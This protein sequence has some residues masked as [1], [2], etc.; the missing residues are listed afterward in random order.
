MKKYKAIK[1]SDGKELNWEL[2]RSIPIKENNEPLVQLNLY[3]EKIICHPEYFVQGIEF[4]M[5]V[6]YIREGV[7][8]ILIAAS[9]NLP[10]GYKFVIFDAF[11]PIE[12]QR[13]LFESYKEKLSKENQ[14]L[15]EEE[16]TKLTLNFVSLPSSDPTKP[17]AH[18]T[19]GSID[20]TITDKE[21]NLL[22]MGSF[23][24]DMSDIVITNYFEKKIES[25]EKLSK[26]EKTIL[27]NRRLLYNLMIEQGFTNF[28]NEW[29]HYDFGNQLWAFNSNN[30]YAIYSSTK[31]FF[32]WKD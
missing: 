11:R 9:K 15:N 19:G 3:P 24:D 22:D 20:L 28:V 7:Y 25:G 31:P 8:K 16:L 29:W 5:P 14:D 23:F 4:A 27:E 10:K 2:I 18:N 6:L 32:F 13:S 12:V 30:E 17:S 1:I 21:G 26:K